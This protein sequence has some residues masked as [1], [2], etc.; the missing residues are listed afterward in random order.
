MLRVLDGFSVAGVVF[1]NEDDKVQPE[2][3]ERI[4]RN[5]KHKYTS[6]N[7]MY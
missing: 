5:Q 6:L 1:I 7:Y 3:P 4:K 2:H